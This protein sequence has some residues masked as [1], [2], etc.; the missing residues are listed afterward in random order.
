MTCAELEILLCDYA[1]G[2]LAAAE[3]IALERHMVGCQGCAELARDVAEITGFLGAVPR[4][5]APPVLV[6]RIQHQIPVRRPWWQRMWAGWVDSLLQP[7]FAMGIAMTILSVSMLARLAGFNAS[8]VSRADL[9]P[10]KVWQ[11]LD[12]RTYRIWDRTV[13]YYDDMPL[14][15]DLRSQWDDWSEQSQNDQGGVGR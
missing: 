15:S 7:R 8:D 12:D 6:T 5:E 14:M 3:R 10:V 11:A 2:T 9:N 4:V 1:D 13:K